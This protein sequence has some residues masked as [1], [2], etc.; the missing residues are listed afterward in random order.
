[1]REFTNR[2]Y[3]SN[4]LTLQPGRALQ[5]HAQRKRVVIDDGV[6]ARL[7]PEHFL[8]STTSG[9]AER[10]ASWLDEWHQ[11]EWPDRGDLAPVTTQWAVLTIVGPDVAGCCRSSSATSI[12]PPSSSSHERARRCIAGVSARVQRVSFC[13]ELRLRVGVAADRAETL[14]VQLMAAGADLGIA[15]LGIEAWMA[16]RI[17]GLPARRFRIRMARP[18]RWI[19]DSGRRLPA[20]RVTSLAGAR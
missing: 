1:M 7:S 2:I 20:S 18:T 17:E 5:P 14:W 13:G 9:G 10:I 16:M 19:W 15:P 4:A 11:C 8:V 6:F 12:C 3:V